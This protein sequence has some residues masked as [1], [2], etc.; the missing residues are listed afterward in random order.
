M[1]AHAE[2]HIS[3]LKTYYTVYAALL[4]LT[5]TTYAVSFAGFEP[6][7]AVIVAVSV[8]MVKATLVGAWFMHLKYDVKFN[9]FVFLAALWFMSVFFILTMFDVGSRG[10]ISEVMDNYH[11]RAETQ[12]LSEAAP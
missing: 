3:P 10:S 5:V 11:Y 2:P 8:A 6:K 9:V 1:S 4:V 12:A 7:L